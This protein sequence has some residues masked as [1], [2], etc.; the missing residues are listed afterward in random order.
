MSNSDQEAAYKMCQENLW[1]ITNDFLF[2]LKFISLSFG[3][4]EGSLEKHLLSVLYDDII[5]AVFAIL[6]LARDGTSNTSKRELRFLV[7]L[8]IKLCYVEQRFT[9][10]TIPEKIKEAKQLLSTFGRRTNFFG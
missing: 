6:G 5:E 9:N 4:H 3:R 1:K 7:E 8:A 10:R 2:G